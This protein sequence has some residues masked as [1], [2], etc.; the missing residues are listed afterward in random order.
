MNYD[1]LPQDIGMTI[2]E[3][4]SSL[5]EVIFAA[6]RIFHIPIGIGDETD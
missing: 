5:Y 1:E 2:P 6:G 3:D 4:P